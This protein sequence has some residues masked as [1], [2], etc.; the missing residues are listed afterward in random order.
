[1]VNIDSHIR[2]EIQKPNKLR[3]GASKDHEEQPPDSLRH[4]YELLEALEEFRKSRYLRSNNEFLLLESEDGDEGGEGNEKDTQIEK[5]LVVLLEEGEEG[6]EVDKAYRNSENHRREGEEARRRRYKRKT[7]TKAKRRREKKVKN[8]KLGKQE[9]PRL[10]SP[11]NSP[12]LLRYCFP[13][14]SLHPS[15]TS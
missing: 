12:C 13:C 4:P 3:C 6:R 1:M 10:P 5:R 11:P 9:K 2:S 15:S 8:S 14:N 7:T